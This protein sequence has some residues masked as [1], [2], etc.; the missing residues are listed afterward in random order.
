MRDWPLSLLLDELWLRSRRLSVHRLESSGFWMD[1]DQ[2]WPCIGKLVEL[3]QDIDRRCLQQQLSAVEY[4]YLHSEQAF[5]LSRNSFGRRWPLILAFGH[6]VTGLFAACCGV[7]RDIDKLCEVGACFNL[8]ISLIDLLLDERAFKLAAET[9]VAMLVEHD[10]KKLLELQHW[11]AFDDQLVLVPP[12]DARVLLRIVSVVYK[13]MRQLDLTPAGREE[14]GSLLEDAFMAEIASVRPGEGSQAQSGKST[15]PFEVMACIAR[16]AGASVEFNADR[17]RAMARQFGA[18]I[19]VLDDLCDLVDD[20]RAGAINSIVARPSSVQGARA[21]LVIASDPE[22]RA[23][24]V[25]DSQ[26]A[27]TAL[28]LLECHELEEAAGILVGHLRE[29]EALVLSLAPPHCLDMAR[30]RLASTRAFIRNWLE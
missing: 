19:A 2:Y 8:G 7:G 26:G 22:A 4:A 10:V 20:L 28:A 24:T 15:L 6:Q 1:G 16:G 27:A 5:A 3:G 30:S 29:T 14:L 13:G 9:V 11:S 17:H 21:T 12:S 18:S 23:Q 25:D